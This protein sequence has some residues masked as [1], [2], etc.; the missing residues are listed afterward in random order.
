[1]EAP[2]LK[3][4]Q[5]RALERMNEGRKEEGRGGEKSESIKQTFQI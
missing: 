4:A 2:N 5:S 3:G 1:M